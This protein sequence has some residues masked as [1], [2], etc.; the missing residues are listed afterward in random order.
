M[1]EKIQQKSCFEKQ[2]ET[3][4]E[5]VVSPPEE[6]GEASSLSI[7][8]EERDE[9]HGLGRGSKGDALASRQS[10]DTGKSGLLTAAFPVLA[11]VL[12]YRMFISPW[13]PRCCRFTPSCSEYAETALRRHGLLRGTCLMIWR[14]LRCQ[15]FCDG[16]Y[17]PVPE[18][19]KSKLKD[20]NT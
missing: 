17:D 6:P 1:R 19:K 13:M 5:R 16:G 20:D 8:R 15:P 4:A 10:A 9:K 3:V 2:G 11:F 14:L 12:L 18:L 7:H